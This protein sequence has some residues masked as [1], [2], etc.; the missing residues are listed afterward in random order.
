M[1]VSNVPSD[2]LRGMRVRR[3]VVSL[4]PLITGLIVVLV[5]GFGHGWGLVLN[6]AVFAVIY[7]ALWFSLNRLLDARLGWW[8]RR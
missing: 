1:T 8:H 5:F 3:L 4:V 2:D 6:V 7:I